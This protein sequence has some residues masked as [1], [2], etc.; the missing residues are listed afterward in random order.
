[1]KL[2]APGLTPWGLHTGSLRESLGIS[3][4]APG[5]SWQ[6]VTS[7][8]QAQGLLREARS[9]TGLLFPPSVAG[10]LPRPTPW[11]ACSVEAAFPRAKLRSATLP[12]FAQAVLAALPPFFIQPVLEIPSKLSSSAS[13]GGS[14]PW[15]S[16]KLQLSIL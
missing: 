4:S 5:S 2:Q 9:G 16:P 13:P 8:L 6:A 10:P 14:R 15:S 11:E 7:Q 12:A 3:W 1:M